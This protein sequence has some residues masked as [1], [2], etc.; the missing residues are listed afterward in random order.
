MATKLPPLILSAR[1]AS[2]RMDDE[3]LEPTDH[4]L[5]ALR[6]S[7]LER[8]NYTCQYCGYQA[9]RFQELHHRNDNHRDNRLTNVVTICPLCHLSFHIGRAGLMG[10]GVAIWAPEVTQEEMN[11]IARA[12]YVVD[13]DGSLPSRGA[14][15]VATLLNRN[16]LAEAQTRL[17]STNLL[18][19]GTALLKLSEEEYAKRHEALAGI[20]ILP[21]GRKIV[22]GVDVWPDMVS[23][24]RGETGGYG[25]H[26]TTKW[27]DFARQIFGEDFGRK[28]RQDVVDAEGAAAGTQDGK[29][30]AE[31]TIDA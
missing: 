6:K 8:D 3:S 2:W 13:D 22:G 12:I 26:P 10:E 4:A 17:G 24:W 27:L 5:Q 23:Y 31:T 11:H 15:A 21:L 16:R 18:T 1:R 14:Y 9:T 28:K 29:H 20:R 30:A 7:V 25:I 19:I